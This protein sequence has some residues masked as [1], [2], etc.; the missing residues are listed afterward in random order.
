MSDLDK[1]Y[2][3]TNWIW[4][5]YSQHLGYRAQEQDVW[6]SWIYEEGLRETVYNAILELHLTEGYIAGLA[7]CL[8]R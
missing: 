1:L 7:S 6:H 8:L 5:I 3:A 4:Y 2:N